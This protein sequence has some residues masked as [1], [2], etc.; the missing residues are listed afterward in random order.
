CVNL[1][2]ILGQIEADRGNLHGGWLL[3][4]GLHDSNPS[5]HLD[6]VSGSHPPHPLYSDFVT[7]SPSAA[8]LDDII[9]GSLLGLENSSG[10]PYSPA[11]TVA[12][13]D[14]RDRNIAR[15]IYQGIDLA[16]RY[17]I[18]LGSGDTV[19]LTAAGSLLKSRQQLLAGQAW[20]P[21]A[22]TLFH[23]ARFRARGGVAYSGGPL[24]LAAYVSHMSA[25]DD[26]RQ[27]RSV[28]VPAF[29]TLDLTAGLQ[30]GTG[31]HVSLAALNILDA[32]PQAI[33]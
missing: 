30:I 14:N 7:L 26:N 13:I 28:R 33:A 11:T 5:W 18:D 1:K 24:S 6:A 2:N 20:T 12:F 27:S 17:R 16:V 4:S 32:K 9:A 21:L 3:C 15:Q 19:T 8:L 23:P 29:T 25:L 10:R 31:T 22:G